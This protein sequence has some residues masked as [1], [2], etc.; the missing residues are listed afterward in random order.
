MTSHHQPL[1]QQLI[2]SVA[3][4]SGGPRAVPYSAVSFEAFQVAENGR[5]YPVEGIIAST[6]ADAVTQAVTLRAFSHKQH[7]LVRESGEQGSKLH[8]FAIKKK[9]APRYVHKDHVSRAVRD[10]YAAPVCVIDGDLLAGGA[11]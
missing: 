3:E 1:C 8:I 10:L 6:V 5:T 2:R 4:E 11:E 9:S 7:L